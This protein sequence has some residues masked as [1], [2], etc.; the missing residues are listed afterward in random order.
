MADRVKELPCLPDNT[1]VVVTTGGQLT[2]GHIVEPAD[3]NRSQLNAVP[4]PNS[5]ENITPPDTQARSL[6]NS[7]QTQTRSPIRT[8]SRTGT[9]VTA[10]DRFSSS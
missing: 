10:P 7:P 5:Q 9:P 1:E 4:N 2:P 6:L 3:R 8:R